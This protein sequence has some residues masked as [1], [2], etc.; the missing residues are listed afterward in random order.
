MQSFFITTKI[1][2]SELRHDDVLAMADRALWG[3]GV[4]YLDLLLIHWPN[5]QIPLSETL[6][7]MAKLVR[8]GKVRSIGVSKFS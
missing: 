7:A 6:P 5:D 8:Q 3:L 4:D 1:P 2:H